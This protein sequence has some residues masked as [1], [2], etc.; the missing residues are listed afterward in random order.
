M[1][2]KKRTTKKQK[3]TKAIKTNEN[4]NKIIEAYQ[5][6]RLAAFKNA[7]NKKGMDIDFI[8]RLSH[9]EILANFLEPILKQRYANTVLGVT[10]DCDGSGQKS[11]MRIEVIGRK[12]Y[13]TKGYKV[14][15]IDDYKRYF[16]GIYTCDILTGKSRVVWTSPTMIWKDLSRHSC[17]K[18]AEWE[19]DEKE[20]DKT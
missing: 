13:V 11:T 6:A 5:I 17:V 14:E 2:T 7:I 3:N 1:S 19:N 8:A 10:V 12:L 20:G 16:Q 4:K 18:K 9:Q 15:G